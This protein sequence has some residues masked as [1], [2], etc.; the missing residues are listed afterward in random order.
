MLLNNESLL[1][2]YFLPTIKS[3]YIEQEFFLMEK[4]SSMNF[5]K[6]EET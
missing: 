5:M 2:T 1:N 4:E 6:W 3:I